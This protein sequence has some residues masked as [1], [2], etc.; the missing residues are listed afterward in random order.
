MRRDTKLKK[1]LGFG[2]MVELPAPVYLQ[3]AL[4]GLVDETAKGYYYVLPTGTLDEGP[5]YV[6]CARVDPSLNYYIP[7][8]L[9]SWNS[10]ESNR[11]RIDIHVDAARTFVFLRGM[12]RSSAPNSHY[13][14]A[15]RLMALY[16][17]TLTEQ[18]ET[19]RDWN[20]D[21]NDFVVNQLQQP[22]RDWMMEVLFTNV[23][24]IMIQRH[25]NYKTE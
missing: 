15:T 22:V 16:L 25:Q 7:A 8:P 4:M 11:L 20:L 6:R 2:R 3:A 21:L 18:I 10:Y 5:N 17:E 23:F 13:D 14:R 1:M 9:K 19:N 12:Y 24:D